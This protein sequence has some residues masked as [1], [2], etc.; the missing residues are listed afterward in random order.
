MFE[1]QD[2]A[3]FLLLMNPVTSQNLFFSFDW[4]CIRHEMFV[5]HLTSDSIVLTYV[6]KTSVDYY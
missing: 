2:I 6:K 3:F 1:W 5:G 4:F